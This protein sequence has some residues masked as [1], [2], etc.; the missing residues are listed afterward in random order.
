MAVPPLLAAGTRYSSPSRISPIEQKEHPSIDPTNFSQALVSHPQKEV[1]DIYHLSSVLCTVATSPSLTK[2]K[3]HQ[4]RTL[5]SPIPNSYNDDRIFAG[6]VKEW[7]HIFNSAFFGGG[8]LDL[9]ERVFLRHGESH[10]IGYGVYNW[11]MPGEIEI[12]MD[13]PPPVF[14]GEVLTRE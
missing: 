7:F 11:G 6:I 12:N 14:E 1:F 8:L 10:R 5:H 2:L 13:Q 4:I 3:P 9:E